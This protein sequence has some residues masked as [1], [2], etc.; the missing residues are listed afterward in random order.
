MFED[1]KINSVWVKS[2]PSRKGPEFSR[3][4][5]IWANM[6]NRC[7]PGSSFQQRSPT[8]IGCTMSDNFKDFQFFAEWC[9]TQ[10]GYGLKDYEIDKDFLIL[11]NRVYS[12][13]TCVFIPVTLNAFLNSRAKSR[14]VYPQGVSYQKCAS[15]FR[16]DLRIDGKG[17]YLGMFKTV[18]E[19]SN[20]YKSAKLAE[21]QRWVRRLQAGEFI[22][23]QRVI[24]SLKNYSVPL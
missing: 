6:R 14:G 4:G 8:Y 16:A 19:A 3:S 7:T 22:V 15:P 1:I 11:R 18:E 21:A 17:V 2:I 24:T 5:L 20:A 10:V 12:E 9:Q 23:D 13:D